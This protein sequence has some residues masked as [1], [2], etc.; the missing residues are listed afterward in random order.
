M[1]VRDIV[2]EIPCCGETLVEHAR[3]AGCGDM[4]PELSQSELDQISS[5]GK[6]PKHEHWVQR[7]RKGEIA[8]DTLLNLAGLASFSHDQ[9]Q[10][11][12]HIESIISR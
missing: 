6:I 9:A 7:I 5:D 1:L 3:K 12:Q 11:D 2:D 10:L 4:F 8:V